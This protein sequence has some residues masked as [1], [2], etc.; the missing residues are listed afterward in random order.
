[1]DVEPG[2]I[3]AAS[4]LPN[5]GFAGLSLAVVGFAVA[6]MPF[7]GP[8]IGVPFDGS[9]AWELDRNRLVLHVLPGVAGALM[10]FV[11]IRVYLRQ[12]R[13]R[14]AYPG[15]LPGVVAAAVVVG[16]WNGVGPW[17]LDFL[18]P[19]SHSRMFL[20]IS[21]FSEFSPEHR[22]LLEAGC[23]WLPALMTL[24]AVWPA[25]RLLSLLR[26]SP[27]SPGRSLGV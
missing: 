15:W 12:A 2:G 17:L 13:N 3:K 9:D 23:H 10:G 14:T 26:P 25:Y 4:A 18:L 19:A 6:A 7:V 5:F 1:M 22:V 24:G 11:L 27:G 8:L 20:G 21:H 16:V